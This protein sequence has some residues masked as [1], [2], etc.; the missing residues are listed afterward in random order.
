[1]TDDLTMMVKYYQPHCVINSRI[2]HGRGDYES[3]GDNSIPT[4]PVGI[5]SECLVTLNDTWGYKSGDRNWKTPADMIGLLVRCISCGTT[6]LLNVGPYASGILTPETEDILETIGKWTKRYGEAVYN[7]CDNPLKT[8]YKWGY[9]AVSADSTKMY[10]YVTDTKT[11]KIELSGVYG[12]VKSVCE[13][14]G[15]EQKY[16]Y[17]AEKGM[18]EI[19]LNYAESDLP[20]PVFR[21][22]FEDKATFFDGL[23]QYGATLYLNSFC[24]DKYVNGEKVE[25][26]FEHNL[27][28]GKMGIN[29]LAISGVTLVNAWNKKEEYLG[30]TGE[31][32][33]AGKFRCEIT[34]DS[35]DCGADVVV[36]VITDGFVQTQT[37]NLTLANA[38][39]SYNLSKTGRDNIRQVYSAGTFDIPSAGKYEIYL[40]RLNDGGNIPMSDIRLIA[41]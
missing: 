41:E 15:N 28:D 32:T 23:I 29:G 21:I 36:E 2:S 39:Y 22:E 3:L 38:V 26:V 37:T 5:P 6:M 4:I 33:T 30:W 14:G 16:T 7:V 13:I 20:V 19:T 17:C 31:F 27:Y 24:G 8:V 10:L 18:I 25:R 1:M 40:K 9:L 12:K 35:T 34:L 11:A